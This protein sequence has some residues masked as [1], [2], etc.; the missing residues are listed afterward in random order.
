MQGYTVTLPLDLHKKLQ[1]QSKTTRQSLNH[2]VEDA[3]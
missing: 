2:L 1:R 3:L